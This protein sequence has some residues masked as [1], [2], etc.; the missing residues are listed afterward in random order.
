MDITTVEE[1][2]EAE[3]TPTEEEEEAEAEDTLPATAHT[4]FT[5]PEEEDRRPD[6]PMPSAE[7][8]NMWLTLLFRVNK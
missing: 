7:V 5:P 1:D 6:D 8:I 2:I 4:K 3:D